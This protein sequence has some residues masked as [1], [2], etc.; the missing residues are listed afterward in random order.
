M[1]GFIALIIASIIWGTSPPATE[2]ALASFSPQVIIFF[3]FLL[4]SILLFLILRKTPLISKPTIILGTLNA[5]AHELQ[6]TG[7]VFTTASKVAIISNTFPIYV[8]ILAPLVL[9]ERL[10]NRSIISIVLG[11]LGVLLIGNVFEFRGINLGDFLS[12]LASIIYAFYVVVAKKFSLQIEPIY[13]TFSTNFVSTFIALAFLPMFFKFQP[14]IVPS[15]SVIWLAVF[16]SSLGYILYF[17][18]LKFKGAVSSSVIILSTII[19]GTV[20]SIFILGESLS[21]T[22]SAVSVALTK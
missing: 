16:P 17:Y 8:G 7:Q 20:F 11:T 9:K 15:L 3:R 6:F 13:Y 21:A 18:G 22:E 5:L 4:S 12:F 1:R 19:F 14:D 2:F 10:I